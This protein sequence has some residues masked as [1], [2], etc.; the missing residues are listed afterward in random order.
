ML[1]DN[2]LILCSIHPEFVR[3][4]KKSTNDSRMPGGIAVDDFDSFHEMIKHEES[5]RW[6][7][8]G[9][10]DGL[11]AGLNIGLPP[12]FLFGSKAM[13]K[14]VGHE[15]ISGAKRICLAISEPFAGSDVAG[16]LT[17]AVKSPDGKHYIVNG[18]KKWIT[19]GMFSD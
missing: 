14:K 16:I 18:S 5:G 11:F 9:Y 8:P 12:I 19:C 15:V 10:C 7:T 17:T 2:D 3:A 1:A 13:A 4:Y 6:L